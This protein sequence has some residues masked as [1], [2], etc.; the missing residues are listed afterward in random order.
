MPQVHPTPRA[1][2]PSTQERRVILTAL[3]VAWLV[4]HLLAGWLDPSP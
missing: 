3:A 4:S 2:L 1:E